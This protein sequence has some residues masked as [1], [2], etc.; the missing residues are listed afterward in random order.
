MSS[1][2]TVR[3]TTIE[4]KEQPVRKMSKLSQDVWISN[5]INFLKGYFLEISGIYLRNSFIGIYD[6]NPQGRIDINMKKS[7]L[8][9]KLT[10]T[11]NLG[12]PFNLYKIG[13]KVNETDFI[14]QVHRRLATRYISIG[15]TYNFSSGKK[16]TDRENVEAAGSDARG[17]L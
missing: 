13:W 14:R 9:D 17:R 11:L 8:K 2:L 4:I 3:H 12:D 15:L 7:F 5:R 6:L 1:S 16:Q 10:A